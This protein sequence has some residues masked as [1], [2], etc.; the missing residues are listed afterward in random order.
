MFWNKKS[1]A[2]LTPQAYHD[3]YRSLRSKWPDPFLEHAPSLQARV[4]VCVGVLD[5]HFNRNGGA[6]WNPEADREYVDV[7]REQLAAFEGFTAEEQQRI[8][9]A[10]NEILACGLELETKGESERNASSAIDV[11]MSRTIDWIL[12]HP[13]EMK[14]IADEKYRGH[15]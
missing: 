10:L 1:P 5:A 3:H 13:T 14:V 2:R 6:N 9:W 7:L 12:A 8:D 11:L 15:E 4:I